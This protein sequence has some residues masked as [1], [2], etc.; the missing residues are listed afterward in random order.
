MAL[1]IHL[2][3]AARVVLATEEVVEADFHQRG[4]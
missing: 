4:T 3:A 1:Q 2:I